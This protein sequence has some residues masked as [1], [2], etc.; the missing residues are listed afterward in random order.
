MAAKNIYSYTS[1]KNKCRSHSQFMQ[2]LFAKI[3]I[4]YPVRGGVGSIISKHVFKHTLH[5]VVLTLMA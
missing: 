3:E 4:P 2:Q 1:Q 5:L